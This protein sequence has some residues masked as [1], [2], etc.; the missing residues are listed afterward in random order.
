M[1][2]PISISFFQIT[3]QKM[4]HIN[5]AML[6]YQKI[7]YIGLEIPSY[8]PCFLVAL[9]ILNFWN[10][11]SFV[12]NK[13]SFDEYLSTSDGLYLKVSANNSAPFSNGSSTKSFK[14]KAKILQSEDESSPSD[15]I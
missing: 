9:L 2:V 5:K 10:I 4:I 3:G 13:I 11:Y 8:L 1:T 6:E 12:R 15:R 7:K 14:S